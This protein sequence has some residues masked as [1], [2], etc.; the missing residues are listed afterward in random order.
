[1]DFVGGLLLTFGVVFLFVVILLLVIRYQYDPASRALVAEIKHTQ[2]P[3]QCF[4]TVGRFEVIRLN[5]RR[6]SWKYFIVTVKPGTIEILPRKQRAPEPFT[7]TPDQIRWF[8]RPQKYSPGRNDLWLHLE[9]GDG[10]QLV[11]FRLYEGLMRDLVRGLKM[12]VS[13]DLVTAY[14]RRRPYIHE[15]PAQAQPATQD[16][17]GAWTLDEPVTLYLMPRFLVILQ[18]TMVLRKIPLEAV[19]QIGAF[20]RL[21]EPQAN[22]LV[23][24]RAEEE[25]LAFALEKHDLFA[26]SLAEAAKRTLEEPIMQKQKKKDDD[27]DEED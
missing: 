19:Q 23:R 20:R 11:K 9:N 6:S 8:G 15:G 21:D 26:A 3:L 17:H 2:S 27:Y 18:A 12:V 22:G 10:W 24:F 13:E 1:V 7:F 16:I 4:Y 25:T 5:G 14:R